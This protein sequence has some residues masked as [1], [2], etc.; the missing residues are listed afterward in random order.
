MSSK[1]VPEMNW[2]SENVA[3]SFKM[4]KQ[5]LELYFVTKKVNRDEQ[6]AHILL[7]IGEKGLR[8]F[9]AMTL[10]EDEKKDPTIVFHKLG[11]Q[12]E[13]VEHF[14]VSR[15]KLMNMRQT[16]RVIRRFCDKGATPGTEMCI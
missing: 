13:P 14:R 2:D 8:M 4:F 15:L 1:S 3:D 7:Q 5:R 12:I 6:V 9:N 11:E 16:K 10:T